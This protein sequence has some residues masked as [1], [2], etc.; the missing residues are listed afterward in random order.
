MPLTLALLLAL[1]A[2]CVALEHTLGATAGAVLRTGLGRASGVAWVWHDGAGTLTYTVEVGAAII[3]C[4]KPVCMH[5][6][7]LIFLTSRLDFILFH[8]FSYPAFPLFLL[9]WGPLVLLV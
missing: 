1:L 5:E 4:R 2:T 9:L 7:I 6:L 8:L 3:V